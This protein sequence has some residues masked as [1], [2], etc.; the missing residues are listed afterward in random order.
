MKPLARL[1]LL[2]TLAACA[3]A[4]ATLASARPAATALTGTVGP[5]FTITLK[6]AQGNRVTTLP[7]GDYTITVNDQSEFHNFHLIGPGVNEAT[8]VET[9][10]T[11]TWSVHLKSGTYT[12]Q[13]DPH[14]S[15]MKGTVRVGDAP[16]TTSTPVK[17]AAKP[18]SV[19]GTVGPGYSIKLTKGGRR[20]K[21][22][23]AG[24]YTFTINDRAAL[25]NFVLEK[26]KGGTFERQITSVPF[27]GTK[28]I[29]VTL[30]K[31][32]WEYYCRP[33]EST[34]HGDFTVT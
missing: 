26:S 10:G 20:V 30:T 34:M 31:G 6:D 28:S 4:G 13:C 23:K 27:K 1:A 32:S 22:L 17:S 24:R 16:A 7:E 21:T 8:D 14:A 12:F 29:V 33:H 2:L 15:Q 18:P 11:V 19:V 5:D 9:T 3:A 25:H